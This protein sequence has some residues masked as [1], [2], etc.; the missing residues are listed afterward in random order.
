MPAKRLQHDEAFKWVASGVLLL[1]AVSAHRPAV[2]LTALGVAALDIQVMCA[3]AAFVGSLFTA[4]VTIVGGLAILLPLQ[5]FPA[6]KMNDKRQ[7]RL[8][9][10]AI[11]IIWAVVAGVYL[12]PAERWGEGM[13]VFLTLLTT[14]FVALFAVLSVYLRS[15]IAKHVIGNLVLPAT[16]A[17]NM[18]MMMP[19]GQRVKAR[20]YIAYVRQNAFQVFDVEAGGGGG[21]EWK[22]V[23]MPGPGL[24][25]RIDGA[26]RIHSKQAQLAPEDQR[27][28]LWFLGNGEVF[29]L[30]MPDFQAFAEETG[31]N[32]FLFNYRG[33]SH[34]TGRLEQAWD[35]VEDGRVCLNYITTK[36]KARVDYVLLLGH[37][38]GGAV[39]AQ[40]RADHSPEGPL[41]IDR[42]FS[43]LHAAAASVFRQ[44]CKAI[45]GFEIK[46]IPQFVIAGL[47]S[48]VFAGSMDVV[49]AWRNV[50]GQRL[51]LYHLEDSIIRYKTASI[52][53]ALVD[54]KAVEDSEAIKLGLDGAAGQNNHH[55]LP[56][57]RFP[58]FETIVERCRMMVGLPRRGD[59]ERRGSGAFQDI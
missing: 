42:T 46:R 24:D 55:N 52:H 12:F 34:S 39:A 35:L 38:I 49:T 16:T 59:G 31:M 48:S 58:E 45:I 3:W 56:L 41:L 21:A 32:I 8:R 33:V 54:R 53:A 5:Y 25:F 7:N 11:A 9:V 26:F 37:S 30:M 17:N 51:I 27:W 29:E 20:Q 4:I 43:S 19:N 13:R 28:I 6:H 47:L 57:E 10:T 14:L 50:T 22:S 23:S 2:G 18:D 15:F 44:L 36:L 40:L 1:W